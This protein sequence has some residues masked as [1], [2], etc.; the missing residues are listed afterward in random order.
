MWGFLQNRGSYRFTTGYTT[1]TATN[2]GTGSGLASFL[3]GLPAVKQRQAG[4]PQ[5][6]LRNWSADGF[7]QDNLQITRNTTIQMGLRYEY[8]SPLV[9]IRYTNSN[10]IFSS[11]TPQVFIGGQNGYPGG[12]MYSN[13]RDFAPRLGISQNLPRFGLVFHAAYGIF[14]TPVD[15][16]TWCNQRHNVPYVF[17]ETQQFDNFTPPAALLAAAKSQTPLN[18]APAVLGKTTVSFTAFDPHAPAEYVQQWSASIETSLGRETTLE[19]GYLGARGIHLQRAHLINNAPPGP[20]AIG[21][22]APPNL[23]PISANPTTPPST[24]LA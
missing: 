6:Q 14:F 11:G 19:V 17:P 4:I 7:V 10:L 23:T 3:L 12:L 21:P 5:M 9:D 22:V 20:D 24:P 1:Q 15:L 8:M 16:N 2:D 18:F 13:K